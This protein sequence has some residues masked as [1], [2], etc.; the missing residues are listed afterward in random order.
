MIGHLSGSVVDQDEQ[1]IVLNVNGVGYLVQV[2]HPGT[3]NIGSEAALHIR[4]CVREDAIQLFGF[5]SSQARTVFDLLLKVPSIGPSKAIHIMKTP[6]SDLAVLVLTGNV[7]GLS[8]L[9]AIGRKTA[10]RMIID[11]SAPFANLG[12]EP[13]PPPLQIES[14][15]DETADQAGIDPTAAP[16]DGRRSGNSAVS[17]QQKIERDLLSALANLGFPPKDAERA[18]A[19]ALERKGPAATLDQ[20]VRFALSHAAK[21]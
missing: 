17:A 15:E 6:V 10:E 19:K 11:L 14:R 3:F 4:T 9:P 1:S 12:F 2:T 20:L 18:A 13:P 5:P 7:D 8:K 16:S 21:Q